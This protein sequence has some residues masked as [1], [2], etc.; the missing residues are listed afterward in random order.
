MSTPPMHDRLLELLADREV[1]SLTDADRRELDTLLAA[2]PEADDGS[3]ERAAVAAM[4]A[5]LDGVEDMP[6]DLRRSTLGA[7]GAAGDTASKAAPASAE[8]LRLADAPKVRV[9][10]WSGWAVAAACL[11]VAG[12]AVMSGPTPG[13]GTSPGTIDTPVTRTLAEQ[14]DAFLE[15][16]SDVAVASWGDWDNPE[17]PG[18]TG[19]VEWSE[20]AQRGYMTFEGLAVND[21]NEEQYQLW[22]IDERGIETRVS[23]AIFNCDSSS[24]TCTV[25]IDPAVGIQNAK[26]FAITIEQ[27]SGVWV[28]DMSRR[29][30]IAALEG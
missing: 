17:Q 19:T 12:I 14:R 9:L 20:S 10:A 3:M 7:I 15:S 1:G 4:L 30:V 26:M 28:S 13:D 21:P 8:P 22:I 11:V 2:S 16:A 18:V 6:A 29:V 24:G 23:G 25:E 5:S 27:P